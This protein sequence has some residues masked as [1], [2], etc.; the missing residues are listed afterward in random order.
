MVADREMGE[1]HSAY[2][3][4]CRRL[5]MLG[6]SLPVLRKS[7][8]AS[9][10]KLARDLKLAMVGLEPDEVKTAGDLVG[11]AV[12]TLLLTMC[13]PLLL[14]GGASC[15]L[16]SAIAVAALPFVA[17]EL[18]VSHP[19]RLAARRAERVLRHSADATNLMIM[20]LRHEPSIPKALAFASARGDDFS[21]ELRTCT[22]GVIMGRFE[23]FEEAL[24]S[25]GDK[26][27]QAGNEL[28]TSLNSMVTSSREATQDGRR[29]ALDRANQAMIA[30]GKRRIEEYALS[31]SAPSM[32]IFGLGILLPLMVGSF[33][34][35]LSWDLWSAD[36]IGAGAAIQTRPHSTWQIVFVMNLLFPAIAL[37][38][39]MDAVSGHPLGPGADDGRRRRT[40]SAELL[41]C[42]AGSCLLAAGVW[43]FL[44]DSVLRSILV[45][46]SGLAPVSA[47]LITRCRRRHEREA[48]PGEDL[49][50]VLFRTGARMLEGENFESS[51]HRA[52]TD[53]PGERSDAARRLSLRWILGGSA[54]RGDPR[55]KDR[56][57]DVRNAR[58]GLTIA[59]EAAAKDE[60]A[61]GMLAMDLASYLKDLRELESTLRN[62]LRPTISMMKT[63]ALLLAPIVLGVTYAIYLSLASML[64]GQGGSADA[65]V[66]FVVLGVFLAQIDAVVVYFMFGIEGKS[67]SD[68]LTAAIGGYMMVSEVA[69]SV[70]ALIAS[71]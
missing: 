18:I 38:A 9:S 30:G 33:L 46:F 50:D 32:L 63:T 48:F 65:G 4:F 40:V 59:R 10:D 36:S 55:A 52:T 14:L 41:V 64:G 2:A 47:L 25:L 1:P 54:L 29:R 57:S 53:L 27:A 3:H 31:L 15:L 67:G 43:L 42:L 37:L 12:L 35:M 34:P 69:Y 60:Y 45:L 8:G 17:R 62:R 56:S 51:F 58:H 26:W 61:A 13:A 21:D 22:W 6:R 68:G 49:E 19:S 44:D 11:L 23:S 24:L 28:K 16:P 39:A 70:T 71:G 7:R 66:F 20:S 5:S